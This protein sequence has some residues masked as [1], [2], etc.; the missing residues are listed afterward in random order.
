MLEW[1]ALP[2]SRGS[3]R[4]RDWT[5]IS[6]TGGRFFTVLATREAPLVT[7]SSTDPVWASLLGSY[8]SSATYVLISNK[9]PTW[10]PQW[11]L[12][13][14][15]SPQNSNSPPFPFLNVDSWSCLQICQ[16][17]WGFPRKDFSTASCLTACQKQPLKMYLHHHLFSISPVSRKC[18][19]LPLV[20][21]SSRSH[22]FKAPSNW[23]LTHLI[24][25]VSSISQHAPELQT[26]SHCHHIIKYW[27]LLIA[28]CLS[29]STT[30]D[31]FLDLMTT[32]PSN[33]MYC[34]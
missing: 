3:S 16:E 10:F 17:G 26:R 8:G 32:Q 12:Q 28:A 9:P 27:P 15:S 33:Q 13:M 29:F 34:F 23:R 2:F 22:L 6:H 4:L 31:K 18:A 14:F 5:W 24:L 25:S 30:W 11:Q 1:V 21:P 19:F 20:K 7:G